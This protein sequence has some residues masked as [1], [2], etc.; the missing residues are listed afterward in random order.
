MKKKESKKRKSNKR[1]YTKNGLKHSRDVK[2]REKGQKQK[3]KK[4]KK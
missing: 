4:N 1:K 3:L 2:G